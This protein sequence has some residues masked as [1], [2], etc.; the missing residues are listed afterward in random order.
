VHAEGHH[1]HAVTEL[2]AVRVKDDLFVADILA[3]CEI[4]GEF[5]CLENFS[6]EL[7]S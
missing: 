7:F 3:K 1:L 2:L 4:V 6:A 5:Q